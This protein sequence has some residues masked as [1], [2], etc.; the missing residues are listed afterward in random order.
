M[1]KPCTNQNPVDTKF[2]PRQKARRSERTASSEI[3][4]ASVL[5]AASLSVQAPKQAVNVSPLAT[6]ES[7]AGSVA[8]SEFHTRSSRKRRNAERKSGVEMSS[9]FQQR[10]KRAAM[11]SRNPSAI[12]NMSTQSHSSEQPF[13]LIPWPEPSPKKYRRPCDDLDAPSLV[14]QPGFYQPYRPLDYETQGWL[15]D[16]VDPRPTPSHTPSLISTSVIGDARSRACIDAAGRSHIGPDH[17]GHSSF[18]HEDAGRL[19][20]K[21]LQTSNRKTPRKRRRTVKEGAVSSSVYTSKEVVGNRTL[22]LQRVSL[23]G[24][25]CQNYIFQGDTHSD[26]TPMNMVHPVLGLIDDEMVCKRD[27]TRIHHT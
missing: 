24:E 12:I 10:K 26:S 17:D 5:Q 2:R 16:V 11:G 3:I 1:A 25:S 19:A 13:V 20:A 23:P 4:K 6:T 15:R 9:D 22:E 21:S 27:R 8:P 14:Q 18:G 7:Q